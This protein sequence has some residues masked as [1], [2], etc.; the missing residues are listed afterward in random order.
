MSSWTCAG[1][2]ACRRFGPQNPQL[3]VTALQYVASSEGAEIPPHHFKA[4]LR[5]HYILGWIRIRIWILGSMPLTDGSRSGSCILVI[6]LQDASKK[7]IFYYNFFC[8]L[9][10][11]A[12]FTSFFNDKKSR[13]VTK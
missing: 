7:L 5:I 9:L 1:I 4:V 3:W 10:F 6:D 11:E 13:R 12:T 8:L 2:V